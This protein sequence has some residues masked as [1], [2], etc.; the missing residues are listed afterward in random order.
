M[1][2]TYAAAELAKICHYERLVHKK[3][4]K[5]IFCC[6]CVTG[7][8]IQSFLLPCDSMYVRDILYCV[9]I[10]TFYFCRT[11]VQIC[12]LSFTIIRLILLLLRVH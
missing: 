8:R 12:Q 4:V 9:Y 5:C 1:G 6:L 2:V 7:S 3:H 10:R 11:V